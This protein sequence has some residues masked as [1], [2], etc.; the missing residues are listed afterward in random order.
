LQ[1]LHPRVEAHHC[2]VPK[3]LMLRTSHQV[4]HVE[5]KWDPLTPNMNGVWQ[6]GN[7]KHC[8]ESMKREWSSSWLVCRL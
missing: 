3:P 7:S 2:C 4:R 8:K 5:M 6:G 1:L